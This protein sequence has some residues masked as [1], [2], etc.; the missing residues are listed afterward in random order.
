[1]PLG[2]GDAVFDAKVTGDIIAV[3]QQQYVN[4]IGRGR[5][6]GELIGDADGRGNCHPAGIFTPFLV[7]LRR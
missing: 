3:T 1:M 5:G 4:D 6:E 7:S 2:N